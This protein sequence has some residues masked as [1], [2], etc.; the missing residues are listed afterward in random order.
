[1][2][3]TQ[4]EAGWSWWE[5]HGCCSSSFLSAA[6]KQSGDTVS[7]GGHCNTPPVTDHVL[8]EYVQPL[9]RGAVSAEHP[10]V[11][12]SPEA[13]ASMGLQ[14]RLCGWER[15]SVEETRG[16][17]DSSQPGAPW[18]SSVLSF[19]SRGSSPPLLYERSSGT[20]TTEPLHWLL[21]ELETSRGQSERSNVI[22]V[23]CFT[24]Y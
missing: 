8:S 24:I 13:R 20:Q 18:L 14:I 21:A 12:T 10:L 3:D 11:R 7:E 4:W 2:T 19:P 16:S 5:S 1:M 23:H 17:S 15:R 6:F 9:P 22:H